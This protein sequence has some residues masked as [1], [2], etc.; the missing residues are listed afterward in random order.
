[1][2]K[3][4]WFVILL[5][6]L[7]ACVSTVE[8]TETPFRIQR[9]AVVPELEGLISPWLTEYV[10][11]SG[12][13]T[14]MLDSLSSTEILTAL[15]SEE[16]DVGLICEDVPPGWFATPLWRE[17]IAV[18]VNPGIGLSTLDVVALAD[19]FSGRLQTWDALD[20]SSI[21][22]Q[23]I[24]PFPGSIV[25]ERFRQI[26]M[27][28]S[29]FTP[30]AL[31]GGT[32]DAIFDLVKSEDGAIGFLPIWQVREGVDVVAIGGVTPESETLQSGAYPLWLDI[33]AVSSEEPVGDLRDF[34]VW[35]QGSYLPSLSDQ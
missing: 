30:A 2:D 12:Q 22:I 26:V 7:T 17:A 15:E 19:V 31:I 4:G 35:L 21:S 11:E 33:V 10:K 23:P 14:L 24:V 13:A 9:I 32:P 18:I 1:M 27:G 5:L 6:S 29:S 8:T 28:N 25:R 20:G 34:L 3:K 16:V